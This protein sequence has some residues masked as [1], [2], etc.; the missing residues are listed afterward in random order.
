MSNDQELTNSGCKKSSKF[1]YVSESIIIN[2]DRITHIIC[3][4]RNHDYSQRFCLEVHVDFGECFTDFY[5]A[6]MDMHSR[7]SE[8]M[9][10]L[11]VNI[12]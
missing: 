4:E 10:D 3:T 12:D 8:I 7:M 5:S 6:E 1:L 11:M 2:I 9:N